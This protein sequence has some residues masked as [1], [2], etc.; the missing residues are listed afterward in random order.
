MD[1]IL[2]YVWLATTG[3]A[4]LYSWILR[5]R[6]NRP[7]P[8]SEDYAITAVAIAGAIALLKVFFTVIAQE[9]LQTQLG[10]DGTVAICVSTLW[11]A[12]RSLKEAYTKI[13]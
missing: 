1:Q 13:F 2:L 3:I 9:Q 7:L 10:W 4:I 11:L 8:N 12:F 5:K 6:Q